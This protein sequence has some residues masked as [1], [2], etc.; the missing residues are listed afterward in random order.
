MAKETGPRIGGKVAPEEERKNGAN[1][2]PG[3][4][5]PEVGEIGMAGAGLLQKVVQWAII[6]IV[7]AIS[8]GAVAVVLVSVEETVEAEG[9]LE[10]G[11]KKAVR[12]EESATIARVLVSAG[13]TVEAGQPVARLDT[14]RLQEELRSMRADRE[15]IRLQRRRLS[16]SIENAREQRRF[17]QEK[18]EARL[19][20]AKANLRERLTAF[21]YDGK[22]VLDSVRAKYER[23]NHIAIDRALS[24]V[25]RV[26]VN[27]EGARSSSPIALKKLEKEEQGVRLKAL[28]SQIGRLKDQIERRTLRA[29]T[30]GIVLG[31]RLHSLEGRL[32]RKG[33]DLFHIGR[34]QE[35]RASLF[36]VEEG[37]AEVTR[38]DSAK[39]KI[40]ALQE[41]EDTYI[42]GVVTKVSV[43]PTSRGGGQGRLKANQARTAIGF[44]FRSRARSS[45]S[46]LRSRPDRGIPWR[47]K[48]SLTGLIL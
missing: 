7:S 40:T 39:V 26:R 12:A 24:Q 43:E 14:F 30:S 18:L 38:G 17:E 37:I 23:G 45:R 25:R 29:P 35:W 20:K 33:E 47:E 13:D 34:V 16:T 27:L 21:G 36:V 28:E 1:Q 31:W 11:F 48:S 44:G 5:L 15:Q 41:G 32:A 10:P 22:P 46:Y 8:I 6:V 42:D 3:E 4:R 2:S 9:R 19:L